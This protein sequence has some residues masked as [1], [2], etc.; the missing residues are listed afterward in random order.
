MVGARH[1]QDVVSFQP[2]VAGQDVLESIVQGVAHVQGAGNVGRGDNHGKRRLVDVGSPGETVLFFPEPV[3]FV[4]YQVGV[5]GF[6]QIYGFMFAAHVCSSSIFSSSRLISALMIFSASGG[7][8]SLA[9]RSTMVGASSP[10]AWIN[11]SMLA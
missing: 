1:P 10:R 8:I 5:V 11:L 7:M 6:F 9:T 3:P 2:P 4:F